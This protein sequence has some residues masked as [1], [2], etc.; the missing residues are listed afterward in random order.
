MQTLTYVDPT[1]GQNSSCTLCP[2]STDS[3]ILYQDFLFS[4]TLSV[5]GIQ[6]KLSRW[7]G[8]GP[9]LHI[10]QLLSSG[11]FA[12]AL[13]GDNTQSCFAPNSSTTSFTGDWREKVADTD[14]AGTTQSTLTALIDVGTPPARAPTF[15]WM[16]YVSGSGQYTINLLVPGC[17]NFQDCDLR[18]T[19]KVT[20]FPGQGMDPWVTTISQQNLQDAVVTVYDGPIIPSSPDFVVTVS[21]MLADSPAGTGS[22]GRY[23]LVADRVQLILTSV[24]GSS[25]TGP[26]G[27][28]ATR[29]GG[30]NALGFFE[31]P[32]SATSVVDGTRAL[33]NSSETSLDAVG[34]SLFGATGASTLTTL[35][36]T[37]IVAVAHHSSG[38][39]YLGGNF[40]LTS[41]TA[42]NSA[43]IVAF[44]NGV[45]AALPGSGLNGPVSALALVGDKLFVGGSFTDT[46]SPSSQGRL[47][48]I[49][50]YDVGQNKWVP[51]QAGVDGSV[52]SLGYTNGKIQLA[53]SFTT[54]LR[55]PTSPSGQSV[56]G[57]TTWDVNSGQWVNS[58]GYVVGSMTFVGNG[59]TPSRGQQQSQFVA[60][61]VLSSR[62]FGASGLVLLQNGDSNG[63]EVTPL[64]VQL[65]S[66]TAASL[67]ANASQRRSH[68]RRGPVTTW[69][70]RFSNI[71]SRQTS[72]SPLVPLPAPPPALAPSV[73]AGAFW[74]NVST[75][76][77]LA[78]IGGNFSFTPPGAAE[79]TAVGLYDP[80]TTTLSA[81]RGS[82]VNG[83]VRSLL[84]HNNMLYIG[85]EFSLP[86]TTAN[87]FAIYD[88]VKQQ[89][90][91]ANVQS[92]QGSS[93][94][95]AVVV[96]SITTSPAKP[97]TVIVA[98]SFAQAGPLRCQ[99]ICS[100]DTQSLQWNT[101]GNGIQGEVAS[102]DY[103]GVRHL[104]S[105]LN[106]VANLSSV[107]QKD[108]QDTLIAGGSLALSDNIAANVAKYSFTN[109]TWGAIGSTGLPGPVTALAVNNR[110]ISSIF[111]AGRYVSTNYLAW[112]RSQ[113]SCR[114]SDGSSSYL[115]FWNGL[116]WAQLGNA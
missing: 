13:S 10:F 75:S 49:A 9:G 98:G 93:P 96:R 82:Q 71:F 31:W 53:G 73:L 111:A 43:N 18:T 80:K 41:G 6:V 16:P 2:L 5:T 4:S 24:N 112:M 79:A 94:G 81:L 32:L 20:V 17:T 67:A 48:G 12:S 63:P 14:I 26:G 42:S 38:V 62:R 103:A 28:G 115:S 52:A 55:S 19:V 87:G 8:P 114:T 85:G 21:M 47:R 51:M 37:A 65:E 44:K 22:G 25:T 104:P 29:G 110:N 89:W 78:I 66:G 68:V 101:L 116:S 109:T 30:R 97:D 50:M 90:A 23:E 36:A 84:V 72:P 57:F 91:L 102:V 69:I 27:S 76:H 33:P 54:L 60:G 61:N 1:T 92:L 83:T 45:L 34:F 113:Q 70:P 64:G 11:A 58:G 59:S 86:S 35:S 56:G 7:I 39:I 77:E 108:K 95:S 74:T 15:T 88:L 3:S 100:L 107:M 106:L 40:T 99:S 46:T 105:C